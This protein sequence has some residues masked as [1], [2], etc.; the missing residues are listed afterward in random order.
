MMAMLSPTDETPDTQDALD[1]RT[2][3]GTGARRFSL[4]SVIRQVRAATR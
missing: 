2:L 4:R 3:A 1:G